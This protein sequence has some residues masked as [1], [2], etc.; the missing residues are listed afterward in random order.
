MNTNCPSAPLLSR[1]CARRRRA[2]FSVIETVIACTIILIVLGGC[3]LILDSSMNLLR[4]ARNSYTTTSI[5]NARMERARMILFEDIPAMAES[6]T[7]V[8]EYGLPTSDGLFRR[9]TQV[10]TNQPLA[11]CTTL[12]VKT[13]AHKPGAAPTVYGNACTMSGVFTKVDT[14]P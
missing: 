1:T 6:N 8:D 3:Y 14:P 2:G 9:T 4:S 10:L 5:T 11:R 13:E 12:I 7:L